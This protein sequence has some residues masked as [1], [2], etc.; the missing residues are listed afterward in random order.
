MKTIARALF[1]VLVVCATGCSAY[2]SF[3]YSSPEGKTCLSKCENARWDCRSRCGESTV[4]LNDCEDEAKGCR[5]NCPA[6]SAD[7]PESAD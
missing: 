1:L 5:K 4:C 2:R 7:E 3:T 6:V